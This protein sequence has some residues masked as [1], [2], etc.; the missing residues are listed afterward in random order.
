[1][2][3]LDITFYIYAFLSLMYIVGTFR[4]YKVLEDVLIYNGIDTER[5]GVFKFFFAFVFSAIVPKTMLE[6]T[7]V[8]NLNDLS[9]STPENNPEGTDDVK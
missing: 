2:T 8:N 6:R 4:M 7:M 1:M 5:S 9:G 3:G